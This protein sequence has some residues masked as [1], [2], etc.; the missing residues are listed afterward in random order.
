H[1]RSDMARLLI[2][3]ICADRERALAEGTDL[4]NLL[5]QHTATSLTDAITGLLLAPAA[6]RPTTES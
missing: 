1:E 2:V 3:H 6:P 4:L 5:W